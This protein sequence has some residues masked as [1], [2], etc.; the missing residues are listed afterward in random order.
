MALR[1][2]TKFLVGSSGAFY[3]KISE[4]YGIKSVVL[5]NQL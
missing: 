5:H 3:A 1:Y 4:I 2:V